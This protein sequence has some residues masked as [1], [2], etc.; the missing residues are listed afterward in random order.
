MSNYPTS[1]RYIPDMDVPVLICLL[2]LSIRGDWDDVSQVRRRYCMLL[3]LALRFGNKTV[4]DHILEY[5]VESRDDGRWLRGVYD[6]SDRDVT[7]LELDDYA[8][9][10]LSVDSIRLVMDY[11]HNLDVANGVVKNIG[12]K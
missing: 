2:C 4:L 5:H 11:C 9:V 10:V 1:Y 8:E 7:M 12:Y 6:N 3:E